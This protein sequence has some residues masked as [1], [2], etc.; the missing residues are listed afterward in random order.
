VTSSA[1]VGSSAIS[2]RLAGE[3]HRDH[4]ALAHAAGEL[5]R[6]GVE[7]LGGVGD[8]DQASSSTARARAAPSAEALCRRSTRRSASRP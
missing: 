4:D 8:A 6:I 1:V 2:S 3:R 5:V 7:P